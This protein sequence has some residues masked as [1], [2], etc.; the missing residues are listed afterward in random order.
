MG[1]MRLTPHG[2]RF[3]ATRLAGCLLPAL[4]L[5][6]LCSLP[7]AADRPGIVYP[8]RAPDVD[9]AVAL[10][11]SAGP[12][13]RQGRAMVAG[14]IRHFE[15]DE[16][17]ETF[18]AARVERIVAAVIDRSGAALRRVAARPD[19]TGLFILPGTIAGRGETITISEWTTE[20]RLVRRSTSDRLFAAVSGTFPPNL[21]GFVWMGDITFHARETDAIFGVARPLPGLFWSWRLDS[22]QVNPAY[23]YRTALARHVVPYEEL[24]D[25]ADTRWAE[26]LK[27]LSGEGL[28]APGRSRILTGDQVR[29][30]R[31]LRDQEQAA[32]SGIVRS[33]RQ[34]LRVLSTLGERDDRHVMDTL[35]RGAE[36]IA[37][38][39]SIFHAIF[40]ADGPPGR[41]S[42]PSRT[43]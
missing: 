7:A 27:H 18:V 23:R 29:G 43:E 41:R 11:S 34:T 36:F 32:D 9:S 20:S 37:Q 5:L 14:R 25:R 17:G 35:A 15:W 8:F 40:Q 6:A 3:P 39:F 38:T 2:V 42:T 28:E 33:L 12:A 10:D 30:Y 1:A 21:Y 4:A 24:T 19:S 16:Q 22:R 31:Q 13:F 26:V